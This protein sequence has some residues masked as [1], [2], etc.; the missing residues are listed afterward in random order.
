MRRPL[1]TAVRPLSTAKFHHLGFHGEF[2]DSPMPGL[3]RSITMP[4]PLSEA[5]GGPAGAAGRGITR[6]DATRIPGWD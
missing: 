1:A 2:Q 3:R 6:L 4:R 5:P